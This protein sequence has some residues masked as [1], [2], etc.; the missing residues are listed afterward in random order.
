[1]LEA[2]LVLPCHN[3]YVVSLPWCVCVASLLC[4]DRLTTP[5]IA[6][7]RLVSRFSRS[8]AIVLA[9]HSI[10]IE[11]EGLAEFFEYSCLRCAL[12]LVQYG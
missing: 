6:L 11:L 8:S 10:D 12:R 4:R 7:N 5:P 2:G 9:I 3:G 1:M